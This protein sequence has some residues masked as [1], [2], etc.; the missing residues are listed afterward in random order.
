[1]TRALVIGGGPAGLMAAEML[2]D[3]GASVLLAE[4]KPTVGRK[5]LMAGKSGLNL[6]K[7]E[8]AGAFLAGYTDAGGQVLSA[9]RDFGPEQ[10]RQWAEVLGQELF[11]GSTGRVFPKAMKASPLLRAWLRRLEAKGLT[12]RTRWRWAG[13]QDGKAVF[14]T[15]GG[16][17]TVAGEVTVLATGGA[18][19]PALGSDGAWATLL[20]EA[21]VPFAPSNAGLRIAWSPMMEKVFGQP[22]K[23]IELRAGGQVSR[24]ECV[25]TRSGLEGGG[26]YPLTP[27]LRDG[28]RLFVDLRPDVSL[29]TLERKLSSGRKGD[30]LSNRL[31]KG[32]GLDAA[33]L[34]LFREFADL[35]GDLATQ[36][37]ALPIRHGGPAGLER[38]ISSVG[39]LR[40]DCLGPDL[41]LKDHP[42]VFAAG[43][44]IDWDA[45]TGGYLLTACLATGRAA[46]IG[47]A[48]YLDRMGA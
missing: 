47:A 17:E 2:L 42:G 38:A 26:L 12:I 10:V 32:A 14:D 1:M 21:V 29:E 5:F 46:G 28:A 3:A 27:M 4:Q 6:T 16:V 18:S 33:K 35:S 25:I 24:G 9:V 30:S 37:K 11:T 41:M 44:M 23:A 31:R 22:L 43:E 36:I 13:W 8:E 20:P 7:A 15:P 39:G 40:P 34:A 48:A 19:W 45:P